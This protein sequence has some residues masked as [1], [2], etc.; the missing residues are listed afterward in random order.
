MLGN[1]E[2]SIVQCAAALACQLHRGQV[3]KAGVDYFTGHLTT[4]AKMGSTWQEQIIG[5]LHDASEDTP[6]SVEQVLNLLDEKL[7]SLL[8]DSDREEFTVALRLL[9]HHLA[10][11]RETYIQR[12][13]RNALA[14]AVKMHDLTHNMD[15]SR[16]PNPTRKDYERVKRYK[17]EYDYLSKL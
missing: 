13:K 17:K 16:L 6:N 3:D 10:P 2:K 1:Q 4:V 7:E 15:L 11:D 14:K 8:S 5:Y 12:I 9:N